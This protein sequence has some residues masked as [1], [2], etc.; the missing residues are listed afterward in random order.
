MPAYQDGAW[1]EYQP[2]VG[3]IVWLED[4]AKLLCFD[5]EGWVDLLSGSFDKI[6]VNATADET[7]RLAISSPASLFNHEG[8]GHQLKVNKATATDTNRPVVPD[9]LVRPGGNGLRGRR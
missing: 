4:E 7:N 3:W 9:Q 2:A 5:G 8:A 6:G 1:V